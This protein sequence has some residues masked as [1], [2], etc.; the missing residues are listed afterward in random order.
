MHAEFETMVPNTSAAMTL[1]DA[2]REHIL[3]ALAETGWVIGGPRGAA[4][5]IVAIPSNT[6]Q[7]LPGSVR[8][9]N[10]MAPSSK[11]FAK[12]YAA[13]ASVS[14]ARPATGRVTI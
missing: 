10:A 4:A 12:R 2:E 1:E 14:D 13:I 8:S 11:P 9:S 6:S 3:R 5:I 7:R